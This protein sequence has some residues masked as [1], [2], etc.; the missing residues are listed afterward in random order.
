MLHIQTP[1]LR[2][3]PLSHLAGHDVWLKM[4]SSQPSGSFKMRGMGCAAA[5]AVARGETQ[6]VTSS[7][8]NAGLAVAVAGRTLGVPVVVVV[9]ARTSADM[10]AKIEAEGAQVIVHGTV[11]DD[12]YNHA[13]SLPGG[14]IHP[15]DHQDVWDG[16]AS[17]IHE[18]ADAGLVPDR[19]V[20]SVGGGGLMAGVLQGM[21]AVGW[22]DVPVLAVETHGADS[23]ASAADAGH[24]VTLPDITSL[25]LTLGAKRV[26]DA[27]LDWLAKHPVRCVRVTDRAAVQACARFLDDHRV[28]VEPACG[29]ALSVAYGGGL[30]ADGTTLVVVCGGASADRAALDEWLAATA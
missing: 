18:V 20:L 23:L 13:L 29:A 3:T 5:R 8:G 12:A 17:L 16:H 15:F 2:S 21:H 14:Q 10:R 11:W 9:P 6:L 4:E 30:P 28:L 25:A 7:G 19:V 22:T 1:L 26:C 24:A 27:A